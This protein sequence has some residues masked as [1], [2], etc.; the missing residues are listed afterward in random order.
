MTSHLASN[1]LICPVK[2]LFFDSA[3]EIALLHSLTDCSHYV[4]AC[5]S[6]NVPGFLEVT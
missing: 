2:K 4:R 6:E 1:G 3:L 5:Y